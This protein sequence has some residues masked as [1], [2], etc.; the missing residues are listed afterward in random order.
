MRRV[1]TLLLYTLTVVVVWEVTVRVSRMPHY[2]L[3]P[4]SDIATEFVT[5]PRLILTSAWVTLYEMLGGFALGSLLGIGLAL[6]I[7]FSPLA[8][9]IVMPTVIAIQSVPKVAVAPLFVVWFGLG[10]ASK[11]IL[12]VT[13]T[14][15]PVLMSTLTGLTSV[16]ADMVD[17]IRGMK[18]SKLQIFFKV[19]VPF[20]LPYIFSGMKIAVPLAMIGA[21][22]AEFIASER[23]LGNLILLTSQNL[24]MPLNFASLIVVSLLSS[25]VFQAVVAAERLVLRWLPPAP[26]G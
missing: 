1:L 10:L 20:S 25:L 12:V 15:F 4:P 2:I 8:E 7:A 3:P 13:T 23:G 14:F 9:A 16:D 22:V 24:R 18:G 11:L 21:I 5:S 26:R 19:R 17:L 6:L